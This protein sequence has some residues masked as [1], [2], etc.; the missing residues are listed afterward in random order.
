[1]TAS[2][3][4][5]PSPAPPLLGGQ[6]FLDAA[7]GPLSSAARA[8]F[9]QALDQGW[10]DP[11]RIHASGRAARALL[12]QARAEIA[13]GLGARAD[14]VSFFA[15]PTQARVQAVTGLLRARRRVGATLLTTQIENSALLQ[16]AD[17]WSGQGGAV[18]LLGVDRFGA[19]ASTAFAQ[20]V[21]APE[22]AVAAIQD[23]NPEV[24][25]AQPVGDLLK[26]ARV[27]GVPVLVDCAASVGWAPVPDFDAAICD[28]RSW[29]G[30]PGV[31]IMVVRTGIRWRTSGP[32]LDG[33]DPRAPGEINLPA[34]A[35]AAA[36]L[37][38]ALTDRVERGQRA[39]EIIAHLR[40]ECGH[41]PD[42]EILGHP[43]ER[44]PHIL[45]LSALYVDGEALVHELSRRGFSVASG[46]ACT[47]STLQPSHVLAA[48]G[49]LTQGNIRLTLPLSSTVDQ[50]RGLPQALAESLTAVRS[51]LNA[52]RL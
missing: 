4:G 39:R 51:A 33:I 43:T 26:S 8:A 7:P 22:I 25:S 28:P 14:E 41:L 11:A 6:V 42:V 48:M 3:H 23:A 18:E 1:M 15:S 46:S 50:V 10:A 5:Q 35:A 45:T 37:S 38:A 52:D 31:A 2:F 27:A 9:L 17:W 49:A 21:S 34:I 20:A 24:G 30:P 36:G 19:V 13:A 32:T 29:G 44:L 40:A 47:A 12:D 16:T